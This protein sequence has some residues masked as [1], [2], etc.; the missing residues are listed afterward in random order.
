MSRSTKRV[1]IIVALALLAGLS[2]VTNG[3]PAA[4][5]AE[6]APAPPALEAIT[7]PEGYAPP[8]A[9]PGAVSRAYA[10]TGAE[11]ASGSTNDGVEGQPLGAESVIG[12]DGRTRVTPTTG[13]PARAIGQIEGFDNE[14]GGFTCTGW[15]IDANTIL[16]SGHCLYPPGTSLDNIA[17]SIEFFPGRNRTIDPWGSC[18]GLNGWSPTAWIQNETPNADYAIIQLDCDIGDTVGWFGFFSL[19]GAG[20]LLHRRARVQGY[21]GDRPAGT[22]SGMSDR[23]ERSQA[24]MVFYDIDTAAGQSGSPVWW[25]RASCGGPCGMAVHSYGVGVGGLNFNSAARITT[26]RFA[27]IADIADNNN[28]P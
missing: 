10:G 14:A 19:P 5:Q 27:E 25:T 6:A 11:A 20:D 4:S 23:I 3:S 1:A 13:Y 2:L 15:L 21:P 12:P 8:A 26:A 28:T 22:H 24:K 16:T 9:R 18:F 7:L 17:E